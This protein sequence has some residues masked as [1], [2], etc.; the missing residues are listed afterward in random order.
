MVRGNRLGNEAF[1]QIP[2]NKMHMHT[3]LCKVDVRVLDEKEMIFFKKNTKNVLFF[4]FYNVW[5]SIFMHIDNVCL[6][7]HP[8][9]PVLLTNK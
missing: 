2:L 1:W 9:I 4:Q 3:S 8:E 7:R 5:G 6:E